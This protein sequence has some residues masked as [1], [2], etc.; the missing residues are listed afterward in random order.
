MPEGAGDSSGLNFG[1]VS[2]S[3]L[4]VNG[5]ESPEYLAQQDVCQGAN[6]VFFAPTSLDQIVF[7]VVPPVFS[8]DT[9]AF[10]TPLRVTDVSSRR[11]RRRLLIII[12]SRLEDPSEPP[13]PLNDGRSVSL[14]NLIETP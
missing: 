2:S 5:A 1:Y 11:V 6:P 14:E 4:V 13:P 12:N 9:D 3:P 8:R 10:S 7:E